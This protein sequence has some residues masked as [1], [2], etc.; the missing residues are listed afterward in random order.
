MFV[1]VLCT[2]GSVAAIMCN[3]NTP[4]SNPSGA[5]LY[6]GRGSQPGV[7]PAGSSCEIDPADAY[8]VCCPT[9]P[10][11]VAKCTSGVPLTN[12][13]GTELFCGRGLN[14]VECPSGSQCVIDPL[15][16]FAVCCHDPVSTTPKCTGGQPLTN[17]Y[18]IELFCGRG[19]NRVE[20]PA[21]SQ[22]I[23]DPTDRFAVCCPNF[24]PASSSVSNPV[25]SSVKADILPA[26]LGG[27][28]IRP[29]VGSGALVRKCSKG[30]PL[31][32][33]LGVELNCGR[34]PNRADCPLGSKCVT[35]PADRFAVCCSQGCPPVPPCANP[36]TYCR[37]E[38]PPT[39]NG[40]VTGCGTL[41]CDF[42]NSVIGK[43]NSGKMSSGKLNNGK[44]FG[45]MTDSASS[46]RVILP[47]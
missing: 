25:I 27:P 14:R 10:P 24:S 5:Q 1:L 17:A 2:I 16:R 39:S 13:F 36:G 29:A 8:A 20:C 32:N 44:A 3:G 22:C 31:R 45:M 19:L 12:S 23:I 42:R 30:A 47:G 41:V 43:A 34:G 15:D 35:D 11:A 21:G 18:G 9:L 26:P 28:G 6:C 4:L 46:K 7:C 40:C 37:Y 33:G 38:N